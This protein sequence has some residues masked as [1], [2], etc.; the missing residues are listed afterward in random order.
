MRARYLCI[1]NRYL[2]AL[3]YCATV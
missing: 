1:S 2:I 3:P